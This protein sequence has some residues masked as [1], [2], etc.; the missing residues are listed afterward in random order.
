MVKHKITKYNIIIWYD[1]EIV[2][3]PNIFLY[4]KKGYEMNLYKLL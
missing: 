1:T 4:L 3:N 2:F